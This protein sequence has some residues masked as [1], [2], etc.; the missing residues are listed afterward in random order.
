[1]QQLRKLMRPEAR[2]ES[3]RASVLRRSFAMSTYRGRTV[4]RRGRVTEHGVG[5]FRAFGVVR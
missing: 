1:V 3:Q 2:R 4:A 5:V